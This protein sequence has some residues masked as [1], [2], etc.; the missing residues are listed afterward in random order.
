[1]SQ[2]SPQRTWTQVLGTVLVLLLVAAGVLLA[3]FFS[4][5]SLPEYQATNSESNVTTAAT[6]AVMEEAASTEQ[7]QEEATEPTQQVTETVIAAAPEEQEAAEQH[8]QPAPRSSQQQAP[9][10]QS[11]QPSTTSTAPYCDGRGVLIIE[12][13]L[14]D[15]TG[16]A[17]TRIEELLRAHPG[18]T[19]YQPG[20]CPSLRASVDGQAI[21][22]VVIDYGTNYEGLCSAYYAAGGDPSVRNARLLNNTAEAQSPC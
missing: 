3:M 21:Y 1:M 17:Q 2:R 5:R 19:W 9:Q 4:A 18:S 20:A 11:A 10:Q 7:E 14:D 6:T 16:A 15:G 12:S 13:V 8:P 22:P